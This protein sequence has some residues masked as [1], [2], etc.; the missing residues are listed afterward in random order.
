M[1]LSNA[2]GRSWVVFVHS[3]WSGQLN[4]K[5]GFFQASTTEPWI[6]EPLT[7][8]SANARKS[9]K[10]EGLDFASVKPVS[11]DKKSARGSMTPRGC[12]L[13]D[14]QNFIADDELCF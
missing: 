8:R 6:D 1:F 13:Q 7:P 2:N 3:R 9:I 12:K 10:L 11:E 14:Q 5:T 4:G